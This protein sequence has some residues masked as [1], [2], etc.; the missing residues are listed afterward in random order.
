MSVG[1][2][3]NVSSFAYFRRKLSTLFH[4]PAHNKCQKKKPEIRFIPPPFWWPKYQNS[5]KCENYSNQIFDLRGRKNLFLTEFFFPYSAHLLSSL[6][7]S[8]CQTGGCFAFIFIFICFP[9]VQSSRR[10]IFSQPTKSVQ[11]TFIN[12]NLSKHHNRIFHIFQSAKGRLLATLPQ[13]QATQDGARV[14]VALK[15]HNFENS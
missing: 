3:T 11:R 10:F 14:D 1:R 5:D 15:I 2:G 9:P 12:G 13:I 7:L 8:P 4:K 6:Q